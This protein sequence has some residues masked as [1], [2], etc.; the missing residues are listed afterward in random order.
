MTACATTEEC[1]S[2]LTCEGPSAY[3]VNPA[4]SAPPVAELAACGGYDDCPDGQACDTTGHCLAVLQC[5]GFVSNN[6]EPDCPTGTYCV[7]AGTGH[8]FCTSANCS[9]LC[10]QECGDQTFDAGNGGSCQA[11]SSCNEGLSTIQWYNSS[12]DIT[13][14]AV[15][16]RAACGPTQPCPAGMTCEEVDAL[17][18]P[19]GACTAPPKPD[20]GSEAGAD[21][22]GA[23]APSDAPEGDSTVADATASDSPSDAPTEVTT[24]AASDA[25]T[26][27]AVRPEPDAAIRGVSDAAV[28]GG[29]CGAN[30]QPC[31]GFSCRPPLVCNEGLCDSPGQGLASGWQ[32]TN[33]TDC[34]GSV[35]ANQVWACC[36]VGGAGVCTLATTGLEACGSEPLC[37]GPQDT[38]PNRTPDYCYSDTAGADYNGCNA[39]DASAPRYDASVPLYRCGN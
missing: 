28:E 6:L 29:T 2:G 33:E 17:L 37:A 16:Q 15:R 7:F 11:E 35:G 24:D 36:L 5:T 12:G 3:C 39:S 30:G 10:T 22:E 19:A 18:N 25:A 38:Y 4:G 1:A 23:D 14:C 27:A 31:C 9:D 32:C 13:V 26:D 34:T 8:S 21:A 20:A